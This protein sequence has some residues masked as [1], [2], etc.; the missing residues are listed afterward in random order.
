MGIKHS[1]T[2]SSGQAGYAT[3]WNAEHVIT[4]DVNFAG[5]SGI[6]LGEPISPNDIA[7]KNYVD[8]KPSEGGLPVAYNVL[9]TTGIDFTNVNW[10]NLSSITITTSTSSIILITY[11]EDGDVPYNT[12]SHSC[13]ITR[14]GI[15]VS[16]TNFTATNGEGGGT[17]HLGGF[18][19]EQPGAGTFT[20]RLQFKSND[21]VNNKGTSRRWTFTAIKFG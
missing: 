1:A 21:T 3:E 12:M 5:H 8:A 6:N 17:S 9:S 20:Y 7:T 11:N 2:K 19:M 15:E 14:N 18:I 10:N 16:G 4:S 13:R